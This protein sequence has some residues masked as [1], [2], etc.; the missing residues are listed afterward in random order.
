M[1]IIHWIE[2]QVPSPLTFEG[3]GG[4]EQVVFRT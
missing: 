2:N 1:A 3:L 4:S